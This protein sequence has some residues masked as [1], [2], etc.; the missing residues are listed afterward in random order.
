M[1]CRDVAVSPGVDRPGRRSGG[2]QRRTG[3]PTQAESRKQQPDRAQRGLKR[4]MVR[5]REPDVVL[6]AKHYSIH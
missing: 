5:V 4:V 6:A 2:L 1:H 3:R